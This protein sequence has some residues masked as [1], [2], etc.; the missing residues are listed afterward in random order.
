MG[1]CPPR[2][3]VLLGLA[4]ASFGCGS[5]GSAPLDLDA[6]VL[7]PGPG[8]QVDIAFVN[9]AQNDTPDRATPLGTS[10]TNDVTVWGG[11]NNI[12]GST[13]ANYFVFRSG[14]GAGQFA[15]DGCFTA[16]VTS[17]TAA[18]WKVVD[19][20]QVEPALAT[21]ATGSDDC[22][23]SSSAPI[24]GSTVYLFGLTATGGAGS[25]SL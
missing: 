23:A 8:N 25:Y 17:M 18:L 1:S 10:T 14:P 7:N 4:L 24:E 6:G 12:G 13:S 22:F 16:P 20:K 2:A 21:W 19:Q 11:E 3:V 9:D 15:F 5:P